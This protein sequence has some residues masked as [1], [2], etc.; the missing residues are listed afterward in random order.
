[1]KCNGCGCENEDNAKF[2]RQCGMQLGEDKKVATITEI[3]E[4]G[5]DEPTIPLDDEEE[6]EGATTVLTSEL[7]TPGVVAPDNSANDDKGNTEKNNSDKD[8]EDNSEGETTLLTSE[9]RTPATPQAPGAQQPWA[10]VAPQQMAP[11]MAPQQMAPGMAPQQMAP[12]MA[13]QMA[14]GAPQ[15]MSPKDIKKQ[16][17]K[18]AKEAKKAAKT[19]GKA[20]NSEPE[21]A[22]AQETGTVNKSTSSGSKAYLVASIIAMVALAGAGATFFILHTNKINNLNEE[23][24]SLTDANKEIESENAEYQV[25]VTDYEG[26]IEELN[27]TVEADAATIASLQEDI[28]SYSESSEHYATYNGL[29]AFADDNTG[30]SKQTFFASDTVLH[31]TKE[32]VEVYVYVSENTDLSYVVDNKDV[33]K[34]EWNGWVNDNVAILTVNPG[35]TIGNTEITLFKGS[36]EDDSEDSLED[37][38]EVT[39]EDTA[40]DSSDEEPQESIKIFIYNN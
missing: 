32:P 9:L 23:I 15:Q 18:A 11:G 13:Q 34:C 22:V 33:A 27:A 26:Q 4:I 21:S 24:A 7:R 28:D 16:E 30:T 25:T 40:D 29:I 3:P 20:K 36:I 12:G 14:Y 31:M 2:C 8:A 10:T 37:G 19:A 35:S 6:S 5:N 38:E 39:S 1:M 17:K